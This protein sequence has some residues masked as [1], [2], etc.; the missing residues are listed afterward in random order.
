MGA[1]FW[2]CVVC[3]RYVPCAVLPGTCTRG[4]DTVSSKGGDL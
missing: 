1:A 2:C 3:W 4:E